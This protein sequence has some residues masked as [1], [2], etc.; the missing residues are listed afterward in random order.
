MSVIKKYIGDLYLT[1]RFYLALG[2]CI[3]LFIVS[4]FVPEMFTAVKIILLVVTALI[5][6]DYLFLFV[7]DSIAH[8][9]DLIVL[10]RAAHVLH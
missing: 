6:I 2:L 4:F 3:V 10:V 7:F 8:G 9:V 5:L 1:T